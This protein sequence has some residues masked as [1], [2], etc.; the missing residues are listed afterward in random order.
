VSAVTVEPADL[1]VPVQA[2]W[3]RRERLWVG[4]PGPGP[5]TIWRSTLEVPCGGYGEPAAWSRVVM[6]SP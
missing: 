6:V 2:A 5:L 3:G 4:P 1:L